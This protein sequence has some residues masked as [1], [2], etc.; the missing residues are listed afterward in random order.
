ME[1]Y[2]DMRAQ[3]LA[4][5]PLRHSMIK[6]YLEKYKYQRNKRDDIIAAVEETEDVPREILGP[7]Y[8]HFLDAMP[9]LKQFIQDLQAKEKL[10]PKKPTEEEI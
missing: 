2:K 7:D 1:E 3:M 9:E 10:A 4:L 5:Q 6:K 8:V